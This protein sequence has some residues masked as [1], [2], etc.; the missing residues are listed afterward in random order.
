MDGIISLRDLKRTAGATKDFALSEPL[1]DDLLVGL[2]RFPA[3]E[4]VGAQ[5]TL[6]SVGDGVLVTGEASAEVNAQCSRC[7]TDFSYKTAAEIQELFIYRDFAE[8][9]EDEDVSFIKD[10]A[11]DLEPVIR[12]VLILDQPLVVLCQPDCRGLCPVCGI[13]LN[14]NPDH[15][16]PDTVDSRWRALDNWSSMS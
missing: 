11:I 14:E 15:T 7:L 6:E 4:V 10:D 9:Y 3:D 5:G 2:V 8:Q 12:D 13:N 1:G 16:H